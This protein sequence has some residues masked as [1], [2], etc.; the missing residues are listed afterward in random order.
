MSEPDPASASVLLAGR[1][2][3]ADALGR[4][5]MSTVYRAWDEKLERPVAVKVFSPDGAISTD[6]ERRLREARV[7]AGASHPHLVTLFDAEWP[8]HADDRRPAFLV[9]ELIEGE[10]L[11]RRIERLGPDPDLA[12]RVAGELG[13]AL[14]YLHGRGI[15]HRDVKPENI[16][17]ED[18][19][20]AV[21]LVDFGI[22][23]LS[24]SEQLTTAGLVLGTAA[25]LSPEQVSAA[26]VGSATDVYSLGL[27][28]LECLTGRREYP[29]P[30]VEA[31]VARL[32]RDP[33]WPIGLSDG[34]RQLLASMTS[35]DAAARPTAAQVVASVDALRAQGEPP[36]ADDSP[37]VA[38]GAASFGPPSLT[39]DPLSTAPTLR[40][41]ADADATTQRMAS[42]SGGDDVTAER[43]P[44]SRTGDA[45][46]PRRRRI[47]LL[48]GAITIALG[49]TA[50]A[51]A[52]SAANVS[53]QSPR[54]T[55]IPTVVIT[56][57]ET[58]TP[59]PARGHDKSEDHGKGNGNGNGKGKNKSGDEQGDD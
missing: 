18:A 41:P 49:I 25:Y 22:A 17:I 52:W 39:P 8:A 21:K 55:T 1:Y 37:T 46:R 58:P 9:M 53:S 12:V 48:L 7:L 40:L 33:V 11:R 32:V 51:V 50:T 42:G 28:T 54:P 4:G 34:W 45:E 44:V 14:D 27:V 30:A 47:A 24:G 31:S 3:L 5:G 19:G 35:R 10:S 20:G 16:L 2:R 38:F 43:R 23:R 13:G 36:I 59:T 26:E 57:H 6:G 29:G 15:V 56:V